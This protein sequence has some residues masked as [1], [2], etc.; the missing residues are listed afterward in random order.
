[1]TNPTKELNVACNYL[2]RLIKP[3]VQL[4]NEQKN[5]FKNVFHEILS[6]RFIN[7]WFPGNENFPFS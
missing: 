5:L 7:H 4:T 2:L 6:K 3:H 1:M